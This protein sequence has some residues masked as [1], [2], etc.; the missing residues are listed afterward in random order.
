[1]G[2]ESPCDLFGAGCSDAEA[3]DDSIWRSVAVGDK[4]VKPDMQQMEM[5]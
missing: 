3:V 5:P 2:E 4:P 1:M